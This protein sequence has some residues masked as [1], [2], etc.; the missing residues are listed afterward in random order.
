MVT[1]NSNRK[2][3]FP[4]QNL[5]SDSR[6]EV[7]FCHFGVFP[8]WHFAHSDRN[9]PAGLVNVVN[10]S[11]GTVTSRHHT[12]YRGDPAIVTSHDGTIP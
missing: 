1:G 6:S 9:G 10:S 12:G 7:R 2:P 5:P 4:I 8:G 11:V 3:G